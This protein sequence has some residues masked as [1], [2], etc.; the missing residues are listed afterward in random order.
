MMRL[1]RV[2][3]AIAVVAGLL[4]VP[5]SSSLPT[6]PAAS[7]PAGPDESAMARARRTGQPVEDFTLG[8]ETRQVYAN[9]NGTHTA[10]VYA[11]PVR[12]RKGTQWVPIDTTLKA[13]PD[14][15]VAPVTVAGDLE[16]SGGGT[17]PL[18]RLRLDGR[19]LALRWPRPLPKPVLDGG[20]ARYPEVLPGVDLVVHAT[21]TGFSEVLVV[22]SAAAARQPA[23]AR[24]RFGLRSTGLTV[25]TDKSGTTAAVDEQGQPVVTLGAAWMW[26]SS[27]GPDPRGP[28][29]AT[30]VPRDREPAAGDLRR[31]MGLEVD[32]DGLTIVPDRVLLRNPHATFPLYLDP[33]WPAGRQHWLMMEQDLPN[34]GWWDSAYDARVGRDPDDSATDRFRSYF[35][36]DT[37]F[38][39]DKLI[40]K[41]IVTFNEKWRY[42]CNPEPVHL[43][44]T[45]PIAP[46]STWTSKPALAQLLG[47]VTTPTT[48]A[49]CGTV[50]LVEFDVKPLLS[51]AAVG[52]WPDVTVA[53]VSDESGT[54]N[55]GKVFDNNPF[56][57][58]VYNT[59]PYAPVQLS[60]AGVAGCSDTTAVYVNQ[61]QPE[62]RVRLED[63]D[64]GQPIRATVEWREVG[65]T[66]SQ[67]L[68]SASRVPGDEVSV[69]VPTAL[70]A[71]PTYEWRARA[72]NENTVTDIDAGPFT[73]WCRFV[74][75]TSPPVTQPAV[76]RVCSP[77]CLA[78]KVDQP[79][80]FMFDAKGDADI[81]A[82]S[83]TLGTAPA[84][85]VPAIGGKATV[86]ITPVAPFAYLYVHGVDRAGNI[87]PYYR[88]TIF[89]QALP[90]AAALWPVNRDASGLL[91]DS[92]G[93]HPITLY[94]GYSWQIGQDGGD[95]VGL[96][97]AE[98]TGGHTD[99]P[100]VHTNASFTVMAW[101][102]LD[103]TGDWRTA[104]SQSGAAH[105]GF[106]LRFD[107]TSRRW[108]FVMRVSD[109][110]GAAERAA[111]SNTVAQ[112]G[113]WTHLAGV[114]DHEAGELRIYV[115]GRLAGR[116]PHLSSWDATGPFGI[117][118]RNYYG[119]APS[120]WRGL[121]DDI[122]VYP[123]AA[124][125][126]KIFETMRAVGRWGPT[127]WWTLD[128]T[129]ADS[130]N[131]QHTLARI[132][133][134]AWTTRRQGLDALSF[135][136]SDGN[137]Y[138]A[139]PVV[140]TDGNFS[141]AAWVRLDNT[142]GTA[143][144]VSQDGEL[145]SGFSLG[146]LKDVGW[147][148]MKKRADV[149]DPTVPL[150]SAVYPAPVQ[151]GVWT[152]LAG[153]YDKARQQL[154]LYVN[155]R[156]AATGSHESTWDAQ[157]S[158]V[159]AR[160]RNSGWWTYFWPGG[161]D[162][163]R[164]TGE[165]VSAGQIKDW[166]ASDVTF[167]PQGT[168]DFDDT[169]G[170][171]RR[172][173]TGNGHTLFVAPGGTPTTGKRGSALL[174]TG[175]SGAEAYTAGPVAHTNASF[176]VAAWV[177]LDRLDVPA[178]AVSQDGLADS[179]F[180][181]GY[182]SASQ[183]WMLA[184]SREDRADG[185]GSV[186][187]VRSTRAAQAST[188]THLAG[189]YDDRKHELKLYVDGELVGT[190]PHTS[191]WDATGP[192]LIGRGKLDGAPQDWLSGAVDEARA[193]DFP[194]APEEVRALLV[195]T[196]LGPGAWWPLDETAGVGALDG[197]G[198]GY[199]LALAGN[200]SWTAG[201]C[202]NGLL[203]GGGTSQ[204]TA[205]GPVLRTD[206]S[207]TVAAWV[208]LDA[209]GADAAAMSQDGLLASSFYLGYNLK[210]N[211]WWFILPTADSSSPEDV[212]AFSATPAQQGV[213]THLAGV[214]DATAHEMRLYVNGVASTATVVSATWNA[215]GATRLG[216]AQWNGSLVDYWPGAIDDARALA[217]AAS[218]TD[219]QDIIAA[220]QPAAGFRFDNPNDVT[221]PDK[222]TAESPIFVSGLS[223]NAPM[224]LRVD[225]TIRHS[226]RGDLVIDLIGPSGTAFRLKD[227]GTDS[228]DDVVA[229]YQVNVST[230]P[231]NG[232]WR[233]RVQ[234][235]YAGD[236][237]YI[238][239]WG[240][241]FG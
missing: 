27:G 147:A 83:Y 187:M 160:G 219:I 161:I 15:L 4:V 123:F 80:Q 120:R 118:Y 210:L 217:R 39:A 112:A 70:T 183:Q 201:R 50:G 155:G 81:S 92:R 144:A 102:R 140:H 106:E 2:L 13:R 221:I 104:L 164:V 154:S 171:T 75:D 215:V 227:S 204:A 117:G 207:F 226:Y 105:N 89:A 42:S 163:V 79:A 205:P 233:L 179:G 77:T 196:T 62:L 169:T 214:Y 66:T 131:G 84:V 237:G 32:A 59:V 116:T 20:S 73:A 225:V 43:W 48:S 203:L 9:P 128:G 51:D 230:E 192:L 41:A 172:D 125:D 145:D 232:T 56:I 150:D 202:G 182:D 82:F 174:L 127:A 94:G 103:D 78:F 223:G 129:D 167:A 45:A 28:G 67:S 63:A 240:L 189:T 149:A 109:T 99:G 157:G 8:S 34:Y 238:D 180:T 1:V 212:V 54:A 30:A 71:G 121:L 208:R 115:D 138:T 199:P 113:V 224:A 235:V 44:K 36:M 76:T 107:M 22:K 130:T 17:G 241:T 236:T 142:A 108:A 14:G 88:F 52:H 175:A 200:A 176:T 5:S 97:G 222:S 65:A 165:A 158:L 231:A 153:V 166:M 185:L 191:G 7:Q 96:D 229:T 49:D 234:D 91:A 239:Q 57:D 69:I 141:V 148:F 188:W 152:H 228:A 12:A 47:S 137:A 60:T 100:V 11:R 68:D 24:V 139:N 111:V 26:D 86:T 124:S 21:A 198:N 93:A 151:L 218:T 18:V 135:N 31:R 119:F 197:S 19:E 134:A 162:D 114:Y 220:C 29:G 168:W 53:L 159:L 133:G 193:V 46:S 146:Y 178:T 38:L 173:T 85:K 23:L 110:D 95:A 194:M 6:P 211:K 195:T 213:W 61:T 90:P 101:L 35:Q 3:G 136:G 55:G 181:L 58:V 16:F 40:K 25:R 10:R 74:V 184:M 37:S 206:Q 216:G 209:T 177:R 72:Y 87:G 156:L 143:V 126:R 170:S 122:Q 64:A 186:S 190:T 33:Q 98:I 132:G